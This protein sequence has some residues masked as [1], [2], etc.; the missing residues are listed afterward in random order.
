MGPKASVKDV[1]RSNRALV[2]RELLLSRDLTRTDLGASTGLSAGTIT[3]VVSELLTDG[4]IFEGGPLDS[5]GGRPRVA[6]NIAP[7]SAYVVG[8]DISETE[9]RTELFDLAM[10]RIAS[11]QSAFEHRV[12][13]PAAASSIIVDHVNSAI[14]RTG[15]NPELVR[16]LGLGVPG[17]VSRGAGSDGLAANAIIDAPAIGWNGVTLSDLS[18]QLGSLPVW[19]DNGAKTTTQAEAWFGAARGVDHAV[20]VLV[21]ASAGAGIITD[22]RL[23]RGHSSSAGEWGHTKLSVDGRR[24]SCGDHGCVDTF[25]GARAALERWTE[26]PIAWFGDETAGVDALLTAL[27]DGDRLAALVVEELVEHLGIALSNLVNL[28][29]PQIVVVGGWFG[30]RLTDRYLGA[31]ESATRRHSLPQPGRDVA[32]RP[33]TQGSDVVALWAA[34]LPIDRFVEMGWA[35]RGSIVDLGRSR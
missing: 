7:E 6:L 28:Y 10:N 21:G 30:N 18:T 12:I 23:Y 31:I 14:G 32:I 9:I 26:D 8:C 15:V 5:E 29:N 16:G 27:D 1:R 25:V 22:G 20:V 13:E 35:E 11:G 19:V 33:S 4:T 17:I 34:T 24:C 2:V 3:S